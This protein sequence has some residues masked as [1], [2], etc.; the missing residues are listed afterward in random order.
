MP[1]YVDSESSDCGS[2]EEAVSA[3]ADS[4]DDVVIGCECDCGVE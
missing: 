4:A 1:G 2:A 3:D